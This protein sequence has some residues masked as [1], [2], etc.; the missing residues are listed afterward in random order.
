MSARG[1]HL[2]SNSTAF[3]WRTGFALAIIL[4]V[5]GSLAEAAD[6]D[7]ICSKYV[8]SRGFQRFSTTRAGKRVAGDT[9]YWETRV[10]P[11]FER[12]AKD[13]KFANEAVLNAKFKAMAASYGLRED[14]ISNANQ[15]RIISDCARNPQMEGCLAMQTYCVRDYIRTQFP[16]A[17]DNFNGCLDKTNREHGCG[18]DFQTAA[19]IEKN[20]A[21]LS[22]FQGKVGAI[23]ADMMKLP[24]VPDYLQDIQGSFQDFSANVRAMMAKGKSKIE[25]L[26]KREA[27]AA[28]KRWQAANAQQSKLGDACRA[29]S[30]CKGYL[31]RQGYADNKSLLNQISSCQVKDETTP[32]SG[33]S[34]DQAMKV[35]KDIHSAVQRKAIAELAQDTFNESLAQAAQQYLTTYIAIN[36]KVPDEATYSAAVGGKIANATLGTVYQNVKANQADVPKMNF[37]AEIGA[38]NAKV[39]ALNAACA[40]A[41]D[42]DASQKGSDPT[43]KGQLEAVGDAHSQL[44]YGSRFGGL[45]AIKSFSEKVGNFDQEACFSKG[46]GM[47]ELDPNAD[48]G[49]VKGAMGDLLEIIAAKG[50]ELV[51]NQKD[52][53][54]PN[55]PG[56]GIRYFLEYDPLVLREMIRKTNSP[57]QA[58]LLCGAIEKIYAKEARRKTWSKVLTGLAIAGALVATVMTAGGATPLLIAAVSTTA[59][60]IGTVNGL[61]NINYV[62]GVRSHYKQSNATGTFDREIS[63]SLIDHSTTEIKAESIGLALQFVPMVGK[64]AAGVV[65]K[66]MIKPLMS[67]RLVTVMAES[68]AWDVGSKAASAMTKPVSTFMTALSKGAASYGEMG[69]ALVSKMS[70]ATSKVMVATFN[71]ITKDMTQ[72]A[73]MIFAATALTHPDPYSKQG[74]LQMLEAFVQSRGIAALG[75]S[76]GKI[77]RQLKGE[78]GSTLATKPI[79]STTEEKVPVV[80][81][82][83]PKTAFDGKT[84]GDFVR[85]PSSPQ[86]L[87][88]SDTHV[89]T[90]NFTAPSTVNVGHGVKL[91]GGESIS[92]FKR[93]RLQA[94]GDGELPTV[95]ILRVDGGDFKSVGTLKP[96]QSKLEIP[97]LEGAEKDRFAFEFVYPDGKIVRMNADQLASAAPD[98][99]RYDLNSSN[100]TFVRYGFDGGHTKSAWDETMKIYGDRIKTNDGGTTTSTV[101]IPGS[102]KNFVFQS[103]QYAIDGKPVYVPKSIL[104]GSQK[105]VLAFENGVAPLIRKALKQAKPEETLVRIPLEGGELVVVRES[106]ASGKPNSGKVKTWYVNND[107]PAMKLI[108]E[109][110]APLSQAKPVTEP[111]IV[112]KTAPR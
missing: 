68:H 86:I 60:G 27:E 9:I 87:E 109:K 112:E 62:A 108:P 20:L 6:A 36:G 56:S 63:S 72:D 107:R 57:E 71:A 53:T 97:V 21:V 95:K 52:L 46:E 54:D 69:A 51:R 64:S 49:R 37:P 19:G 90:T 17:W 79:L 75:A 47:K 41:A 94:T 84:T 33:K 50:K 26:K 73:A 78:V 85:A 32:E 8:E 45:L 38:F 48:V 1:S 102:N 110:A 99:L 5:G 89:W 24:N 30:E 44:L 111:P 76:G 59:I 88:S 58:M 66:T 103:V 12:I 18:A 98:G 92:T 100:K 74:M 31:G 3:A 81:K 7:P 42:S 93:V 80:T 4:A 91:S 105:D 106:V 13:P 77:Y 61:V 83:A 55:D 14:E 22:K 65:S 101:K 15:D 70:S 35:M 11:D 28:D 104:Y 96:N 40:A 34:F 29:F 39:R 25:D 16:K 43:A 23:N 67:S 2:R 82:T 10:L